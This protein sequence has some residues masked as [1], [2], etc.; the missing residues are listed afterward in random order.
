MVPFLDLKTQYRQIKAEMDRAVL[1][2]LASGRFT[3]GPQV[4]AFE[5]DFSAFCDTSQGI[6]VNSGTSA[7]HLALLA[8]G[9]GAGDEVITTPLT[10]VAT[11]S[12]IC[13]TGARPVFVDVDPHSLTLNPAQ[14]EAAI[15]RRTKAVLPVHLHGQ[16]ADMDAILKISRSHQLVVIED[17]AQAHGATCTG[18][19]VGCLGDIACFSFYPGKNLGAYGEGGMLVTN[20][21]EYARKIRMLR[22]CGQERKY[23]HVLLG[24]NY[25]MAEIQ[26]AVLRVKLKYLEE[27]TEKRRRHA[28]VYSE[29]F[30]DA[31]VGGPIEMKGRTHV[32]HVYALRIAQRDALQSSLSNLGIQTG[33]HYPVP[34]HLQEG[35]RDLGYKVGDFPEAES[36][37]QMTLSLPLYPELHDA[38]IASV[39]DA[40]QAFAKDIRSNDGEELACAGLRI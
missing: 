9:I 27:W 18:R 14:I 3:Q 28:R 24:Y 32:F 29:R 30:A 40:V 1:D 15:T 4:A 21:A 7:L 25:R 38:Q 8:A 39:V 31:G 10:F 33:I 11:A 19:R 13:Y 35:F 34:V 26:A 6:A 20:R 22:D 23:H 36:Y 12:A 37:A 2:V 5:Q 17:A 16:A